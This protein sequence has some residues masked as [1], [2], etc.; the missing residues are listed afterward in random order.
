M[1]KVLMTIAAL[2]SLYSCSCFALG[3]YSVSDASHVLN[4]GEQYNPIDVSEVKVFLYPPKFRYKI[5]G[6]IE[7]LGVARPNIIEALTFS[8]RTGENE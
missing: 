1:K 5:I 2:L 8:P 7:A 3:N 6:T 4:H